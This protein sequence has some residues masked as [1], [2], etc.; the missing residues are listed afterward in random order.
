AAG[1]QDG[2][3]EPALV[4][5]LGHIT[6][7]CGSSQQHSAC[8][9]PP[10]RHGEPGSGFVGASACNL[11]DEEDSADKEDSADE[12]WGDDYDMVM[13]QAVNERQTTIWHLTM[14]CNMK[15]KSPSAA[16]R[17]RCIDLLFDFGRMCAANHHA[18]RHANL[19]YEQLLN[20]RKVLLQQRMQL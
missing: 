9:V 17:E 11:K 8:L 19:E 20:E 18:N 6:T 1:I 15:P 10:A 16:T 3:A 14:E 4:T 13:Q 7:G 12:D 2:K 5:V